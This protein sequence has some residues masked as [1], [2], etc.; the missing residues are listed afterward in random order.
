ML[1]IFLATICIS[2][3]SFSIS[4]VKEFVAACV[5]RT[6]QKISPAVAPSS[7]THPSIQFDRKAHYVRCTCCQRAEVKDR[8][9]GGW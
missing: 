6:R 3:T 9:D 4:L 1:A 7:R 2:G 5:S 8:Q